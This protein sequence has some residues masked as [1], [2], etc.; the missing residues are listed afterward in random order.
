MPP[1]RSN[2]CSR[3][4]PVELLPISIWVA[5][6]SLLF[7]LSAEYKGKSKIVFLAVF[8]EDMGNTI[9]FMSGGLDVNTLMHTFSDVPEATDLPSQKQTRFTL[10]VFW[11]ALWCM[12]ISLFSTTL[13]VRHHQW[14]KWSWLFVYVYAF[15][16]VAMLLC[17][18]KDKVLE[19]FLMAYLQRAHILVF[20]SGQF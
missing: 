14:W 19:W 7:V 20:H 3:K 4:R 12:A 18:Y 15:F 2:V 10:L 17:E 1:Q 13:T 9:T 5:C 11:I 16:C 6:V 8:S